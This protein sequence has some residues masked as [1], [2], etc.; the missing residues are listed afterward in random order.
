MYMLD[1]MIWGLIMNMIDIW[2]AWQKV[3]SDPKAPPPVYQV[4]SL[5]GS[6]WIPNGIENRESTVW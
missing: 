6:F 3:N 2:G 4:I 5:C 1:Y